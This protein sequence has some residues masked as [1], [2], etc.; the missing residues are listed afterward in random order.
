MKSW[1]NLGFDRH[2]TYSKHS[3][4]GEGCNYKFNNLFMCMV[5]D[6]VPASFNTFIFH[7]Q[8]LPIMGLGYP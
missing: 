5:C 4:V 3:I 8:P 1:A 2:I 6:Q 7:L